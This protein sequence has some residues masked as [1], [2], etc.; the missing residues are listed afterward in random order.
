MPS[1]K[2]LGGTVS[3]QNRPPPDDEMTGPA[4]L[5]RMAK[6]MLDEAKGNRLDSKTKDPDSDDFLELVAS[7]DTL[8]R[9]AEKMRRRA[10]AVAA[11][12]RR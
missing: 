1:V 6:L 10:N 4:E 5:R 7:A 11:K 3:W 9:F 12:V 2:M 8:E